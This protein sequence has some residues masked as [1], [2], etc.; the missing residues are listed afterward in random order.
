MNDTAKYTRGPEMASLVQEVQ[1]ERFHCLKLEHL[2]PMI[3]FLAVVLLAHYII[4]I[5]NQTTCLFWDMSDLRPV[6]SKMKVS[7]ITL[8]CPI[9]T[10]SKSGVSVY[11]NHRELRTV[12][13]Q[14]ATIL[15]HQSISDEFQYTKNE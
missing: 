11:R 12:I 3:Q 2:P 10:H 14:K 13:L 5:F 6:N 4:A 15:S 1:I 9:Y 7:T 8:I